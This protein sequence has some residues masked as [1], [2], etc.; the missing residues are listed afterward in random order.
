MVSAAGNITFD[1][2]DALKLARFWAEVLEWNVFH[3]GSPEVLVAPTYPPSGGQPTMLFI[4]VPEPRAGKNRVHVDLEPTDRT[5]DEEV[6]RLLELGATVVE[7]HRTADGVGWVW[8]ADPE[9]NDFCVE[10]S[11]GERKQR[12][13]LLMVNVTV[14]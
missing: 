5:R 7:D 13:R 3:D 9:G 8:M 1:C 4:P 11:A 12:A 10:R 6:Q 14:G 2:T